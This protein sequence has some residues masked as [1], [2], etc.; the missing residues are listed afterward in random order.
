[1]TELCRTFDMTVLVQLALYLSIQ[2][3]Y[4]AHGISLSHQRYICK[5]LLELGLVECY[6]TSLT[7]DP[8]T[9]LSSNM[10]APLVDA[11]YYRIVVGK[12]LH[13]QNFRPDIVFAVGLVSRFMTS[14]QQPHLDAAIQIFSLP[15]G[16]SHLSNSLP[17]GELVQLL[18]YSDSDYAGDV[19]VRRST[20]SFLFSL[21][22]GPISWSSKRNSEVAQ[23]SSEAEYRALAEAAKEA[24]W[25]RYL[26]N[27]MGVKLDK[28]IIISCDNQSCIKMAKNPVL[29][30]RTKHTEAQCHFIRDYIKKGRIQLEFVCTNDQAADGLPKPLSKTRFNDIINMLQMIDTESQ[31]KK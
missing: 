8:G 12:L 21:G 24:Q 2:F 28:P 25:I 4:T 17:T 11:T 23:S 7:L 9:K 16:S 20:S 10:G 26:L 30:T 6:G 22:S 5:C 31:E 15:Q 27:D 1:M 18:G 13:L 19:E 29:H 3:L 14:P